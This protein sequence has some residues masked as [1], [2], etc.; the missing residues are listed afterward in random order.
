MD[1]TRRFKQI[2]EFSFFIGPIG[3]LYILFFIIP[4]GGSVLYSFTDWDG[5]QKT[6]H[7]IGFANYVQVF[8]ADENFLLAIIFTSKFAVLNFI[9]INF[10]GLLL[11][12]LVDTKLKSRTFLRTVFFSPNVLSL[13]VVGFLW[14]FLFS[15]V[16]FEIGKTHH[17]PF[18]TFSF[19]GNP[20][21]VIYSIVGVSVW[22]NVGLAMLIYLAGLQGIPSE[23]K[24]A[25]RVDGVNKFQEF[26][27]LTLPL[28]IPAFISNVFITT[29]QSLKV[30][31]VILALTNGGPANSSQSIAMNIYREAFTNNSFGSGTAKSIVFCLMI[32]MITS[33]QFWIL[34]KREV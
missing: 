12:L 5:L 20:D 21:S 30:F 15:S 13:I 3:L 8:R 23:L 32:L 17:L 1:F 10:I 14:K 34:N 31:D 33:L 18:L 4:L 24:E 29:T 19:L 11:A 28:M 26:M 7:W 2:S 25:M 16:F 6:F 22:Q 27:K 9:F